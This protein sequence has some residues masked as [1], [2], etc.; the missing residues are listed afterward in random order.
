M[1]RLYIRQ[2]LYAVREHPLV[3][4]LTM[5]G[6][7]LS[8]AMIM[9]L[10]LLCQAQ[11]A[12]FAPVS[13]RGRMLYVTE[14]RG[15]K[16]NDRPQWQ[17]ELGSRI[18]RECFYPMQT[19]ERVSAAAGSADA[20]R[21]SAAGVP[22]VADSRVRAVDAAFWEVFDFR[23]VAGAPF[24]EEMFHSARP[25]A[26]VCES[27]ARKFFGRTDVAGETLQ[28][29]YA[30]YTV[31]GVVEDVSEAVEEVSG[32]VWIPYTLHRG[33][34]EQ[35]GAEG[36]CNRLHLY[37]LARSGEDFVAIGEE[38]RQRL[39]AFNAGQKEWRATIWS[40]PLTGV[41]RMFYSA[42]RGQVKGVLSG[43]L[44]LAALFFLLPVCNLLGIVF[45]QIQQRSGEIGIRKAFGAGNRDIVGQILWENLFVTLCGGAAGVLLS[46][47]FFY[48]A[49]DSLLERRDVTLQAGMFFQPLLFLASTGLC[50]L[51]NL[52][53]AGIPAWRMARVPVIHSLNAHSE[54]L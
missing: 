27:V 4:F 54:S 34:M 6:T 30:D 40:Q 18:V 48:L 41:Q 36:I 29:D 3:C 38:C 8:V 42:S 46:F 43:M 52:A 31:A 28:L 11:T 9:V 2:A 15:D 35:D 32:E 7:A 21:T 25:V 16:I 13:E 23:F 51:I 45:S 44:M 5:L 33:I 53:A 26:V 24:T 12:S 37:L 22:V 17:G 20:M 50:L 1:Y 47:L 10:V 39:E 14:I 49:K 19:P